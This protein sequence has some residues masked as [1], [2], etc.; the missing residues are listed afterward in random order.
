MRVALLLLVA[1]VAL[2]ACQPFGGPEA[3]GPTAPA[4]DAGGPPV[5]APA[6]G[7]PA[8]LEELRER[9]AGVA[10]EWQD[11]PVLA[12]V[13]IDLDAEGAWNAARLTYL[14][15]DADRF[16][17]LVTSGSG[18]SQQR[19]SLATFDLQPV[20]G[21]GL[22]QL[23]PFPDDA[24]EPAALAEAAAAACEVGDA[25]TVLYVTGAPVAWDGTAWSE[26]P[27][28]RATVTGA[29]AAGAALAVTGAGEV[30]CLD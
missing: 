29:E 6:R 25:P 19:P 23:P 2:T 28:W 30:T 11:E 16:L 7:L 13:E 8:S 5:G 17:S 20:T 21:E 12:E 9:G 22:D 27:V 1:V 10:R 4:P 14:A 26:P 3:I 15:A 18:F 24:A